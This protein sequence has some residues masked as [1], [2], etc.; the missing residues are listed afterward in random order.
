MLDALGFRGIWKRESLQPLVDSLESLVAILKKDL[1]DLLAKIDVSKPV[2]ELR[3]LSDTVVF[4]VAHDLPFA[5]EVRAAREAQPNK[6]VPI[7]PFSV[8]V[9]AAF[10]AL[11]QAR[12]AR[13]TVPLAFRGAIGFG[14]FFVRENFL[15]GPAIDEVAKAHQEAKGAI[16]FVLPSARAALA[17]YPPKLRDRGLLPLVLIPEFW[18]PLK[19]LRHALGPVINPL[20]LPGSPEDLPDRILKT[21][22]NPRL[23]SA[24]WWKR[25]ATS[26]L[27]G[28]ARK[29]L[30]R[31]G[32]GQ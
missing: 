1:D 32:G 17:H 27:L 19:R 11:L 25:R 31:L 12:A 24:V 10:S 16:V 9:A 30:M 2:I 6:V 8:E 29:H 7:A 22:G 13:S 15:V 20:A 14:E 18:V 21:F 26:R 3:F 28:T 4:T 23:F 5:G